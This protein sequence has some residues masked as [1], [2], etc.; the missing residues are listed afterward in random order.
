M[1]IPTKKRAP[2]PPAIVL[3]QSSPFGR[4]P[5]HAL[6]VQSGWPRW[7]TSHRQLSETSCWEAELVRRA[8]L[9]VKLGLGLGIVC[10]VIMA[11]FDGL[12]L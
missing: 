1:R 10:H 3:L 11:R 6:R 12:V 7:R 2:L 4:V 8:N 9:F 5:A